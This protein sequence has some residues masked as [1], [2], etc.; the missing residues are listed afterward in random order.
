MTQLK[1]EKGFCYKYP[2]M[3][4]TVDLLLF[5]NCAKETTILL[6]KR[7]NDPYENHWALPG[8]FIDMDEKVADAARRE[9]Q[10]ETGVK[11]DHID[12][13]G[14]YDD[15]DRDPRGRTVSFAF[16][17]ITD[18]SSHRVKA[19][20]DASDAQWYAIHQ[21]PLLAFDHQMIIEQAISKLK[22]K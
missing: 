14:Y 10:E 12:F 16:T 21:L 9:L 4:T 6:I 20:D 15:I 5:D 7:K 3:S 11:I 8:G 22:L 19:A 18:K 1:K 13:L 17:A 2:R